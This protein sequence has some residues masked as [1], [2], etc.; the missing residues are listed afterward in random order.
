M[1]ESR[2]PEAEWQNEPSKVPKW[3]SVLNKL[4]QYIYIYILCNNIK[5]KKCLFPKCEC[6]L[7]QGEYERE[8]QID[9]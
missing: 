8:F 7:M 6:S 4:T 9:E 5:Q 2:Q 3:G 1:Y